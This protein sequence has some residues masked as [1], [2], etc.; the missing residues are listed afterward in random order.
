MALSKEW[1]RTKVKV[2]MEC[3]FELFVASKEILEITM[4]IEIILFLNISL[5]F[6]T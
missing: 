1:G 5:N 6:N 3:N 4:N 2:R